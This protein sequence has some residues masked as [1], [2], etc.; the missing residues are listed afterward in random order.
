MSLKGSMEKVSS[1]QS[2]VSTQHSALSQGLDSHHAIIN[3]IT[4]IL[5]EVA[6]REANG[7]EVEG[8]LGAMLRSTDAGN[9]HG[10][11]GDCENSLW[12]FGGAKLVGVLRLV[13]ASLR[14]VLTP[15]R[16]TGLSFFRR[17]RH[18]HNRAPNRHHGALRRISRSP[19]PRQHFLLD[20][21]Q[22]RK[23]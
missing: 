21:L 20:R 15:L 12:N 10:A 19:R 6:V 3:S 16:M 2:A 4:V 18:G 17:G 9:S 23:S 7:N 8:P 14:E 11:D 22:D 13:R 1:Q 5:S